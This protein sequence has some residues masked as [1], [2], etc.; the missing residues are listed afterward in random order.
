MNHE[1]KARNDQTACKKLNLNTEQSSK[2]VIRIKNIS[3]L[4]KKNILPGI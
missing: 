4:A 3:L 2:I 1:S